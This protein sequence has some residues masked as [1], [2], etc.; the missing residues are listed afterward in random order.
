MSRPIQKLLI[1]SVE[2]STQQYSFYRNAQPITQFSEFRGKR[3]AIGL[4]GTVVRILMMKGLRAT[5]ALDAETRVADLDNDQAVDALAAGTIDAAMFASQ[6][7]GAV[8]QRA[9]ANPEI[10]LMNVA[11]AE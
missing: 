8:L 4:P 1:R 6:L 11:Q 9:L 5:N 10:R 2:Y 3:I 7:D